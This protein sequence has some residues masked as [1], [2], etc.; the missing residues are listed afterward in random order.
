MVGLLFFVVLSMCHCHVSLVVGGV[1][2]GGLT[3]SSLVD[4]VLN[5]STFSGISQGGPVL[6]R[7]HSAAAGIV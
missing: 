3:V 1:Y 5:P 7:I 2:A 4:S 6:G